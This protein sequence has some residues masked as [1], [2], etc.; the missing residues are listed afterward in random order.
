MILL[1]LLA[2]VA[3]VAV[4]IHALVLASDVVAPTWPEDEPLHVRDNRA[5]DLELNHLVRLVGARDPAALHAQLVGIV[6]R[7]LSTSAV[8]AGPAEVDPRATLPG[9]VRR[10][11]DAPPLDSPDRYRR[12]LAIALDTLEAL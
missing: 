8:V 3:L 7:L 11:L 5:H 10:F 4:A 9:G 6:D 2:A 1:W 12:E